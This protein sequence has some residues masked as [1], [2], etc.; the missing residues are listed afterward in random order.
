MA[1]RRML[2]KKIIDSDA[3]LEMPLSAQALYFHLIM[4]A[5][6]SGNVNAD[7]VM[8]KTSARNDDYSVLLLKGYISEYTNHHQNVYINHWQIHNTD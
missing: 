7:R 2:T 5:D 3:F 1:E 8:K 6:D 4:S